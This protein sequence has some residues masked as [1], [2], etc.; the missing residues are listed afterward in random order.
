MRQN[1]SLESAK[2]LVAESHAA[3]IDAD[4][5]AALDTPRTRSLRSQ[6]GSEVLVVP[7]EGDLRPLREVAPPYCR[8]R[9][10]SRHLQI[11]GLMPQITARSW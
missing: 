5:A 10:K 7:P 3:G 1:E 9:T 2:L 11:I 8:R 6:S 4:Q